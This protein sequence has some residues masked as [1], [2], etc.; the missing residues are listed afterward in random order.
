[1]TIVVDWTRGCTPD[2]RWARFSAPGIGI[3][4]LFQLLKPG[5]CELEGCGVAV[6]TRY[7]TERWRKFTAERNEA[8]ARWGG[9][10]TGVEGQP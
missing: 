5:R 2:P 6:Y 4:I 3:R 10:E 1:M 7:G 9:S 8:E